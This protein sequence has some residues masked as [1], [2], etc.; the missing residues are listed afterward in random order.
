MN[1][2]YLGQTP[3]KDSAEPFAPNI[4]STDGWELEGVFAPGMKEFYYTVD[5]GI[6]DGP[7]KTGFKPTVIG[8]RQQGNTWHQFTQFPRT[9]EIG[10]SP[11]GN[12]MYMAKGYKTR[13]E[14]GWS[15]RKS[16]GPML[17]NSKFGMM[18]LSAS[19]HETY[20]FDDYLTDQLYISSVNKGQRQVP[21]VMG[22][23]FN[24]GKWTAHPLYCA[25][26]KLHYLGQ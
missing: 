23:E 18:R 19:A 4:I 26:R 15:E 25:R 3:P 10:F 2:P 5:R 1:G 12:I 20:V 14:K 17:D 13:T 7:N 21:E 8:Y 6:Y 16:Q 22:A 9:G 24:Q 11:D